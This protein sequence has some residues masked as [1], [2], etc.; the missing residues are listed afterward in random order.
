MKSVTVNTGARPIN[1]SRCSLQL[2]L[3]GPGRGHAGSGSHGGRPAGDRAGDQGRIRAEPRRGRRGALGH[4]LGTLVPCSRGGFLTDR[5]GERIV[6]GRAGGV[7]ALAR[8]CRQAE[9]F[10]QLYTLLFL[11]G[12]AGASV[13]SATGRAVMGCSTPRSAASRSESGRRQFPW[14][15]S[16]VRSSCLTSRCITRTQC[17]AAL[18]ARGAGRSDLPPRAGRPSARSRRCRVDAP[19]SPPLAPVHGQWPLRRGAD[20]RP[21]LRRPLP[22]RRTRHGEGQAP[23]CSAPSRSGRSCC[24]SVP[25]AGRTDAHAHCAA[26]PDRDCDERRPR[27]R[28]CVAEGAPLVLLVPPSSSPAR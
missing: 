15:G 20:G 18:P 1:P 24:E 4:W 8:R 23:P 2:A 19:R 28:D 9:T 14:A 10:W 7:W 3:D 16:S 26:R 22:A 13:N 12:A 11:A 21:W 27:S 25:A 17:S 6:L 5:L